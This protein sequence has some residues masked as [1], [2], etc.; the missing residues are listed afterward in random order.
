MYDTY[1]SLVRLFLDAAKA[2]LFC[3]PDMLFD[4][5]VTQERWWGQV[6]GVKVEVTQDGRDAIF[7]AARRIGT[8]HA[9][10]TIY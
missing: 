9:E 4:V 3:L 8:V 1:M 10:A 7:L 2:C 6:G 5:D